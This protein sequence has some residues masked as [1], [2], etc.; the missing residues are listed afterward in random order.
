MPVAKARTSAVMNTLARVKHYREKGIRNDVVHAV[1]EK[2]LALI[3][4]AGTVKELN[5]II[6]EPKPHYNGNCFITSEYGVPEE[7]MILWSFASL[8]GGG[9][10]SPPAFER[11]MSLFKQFFGAE[12]TDPKATFTFRTQDQ[13]EE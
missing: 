11:Y 4:K 8:N 5:T 13:E 12:P 9:P 3:M 1:F 6:E 7:E 2:R 10:L